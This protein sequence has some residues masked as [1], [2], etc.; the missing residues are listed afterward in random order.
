MTHNNIYEYLYLAV[1]A[2]LKA[3]SKIMEVFRSD[4]FEVEQK[5]DL[6]PVTIADKAASKI[7]EEL[8][9]SS[10]LP[11]LSEEEIFSPYDDRKNWDLFWCVDPLDGTKEFIRKGH[12]FTV[13]IALI[14]RNK[15]I[16]GVVYLPAFDSI[17]FGGKSITARKYEQVKNA[18]VSNIIKNSIQL[19][20]FQNNE[21]FVMV[22]SHSHLNAETKAYFETVFEEKGSG[23]VEILIR[24]SSLKMCLIAEGSADYYPRLSHIM[25]WDI[26][27]GH[28]ICE[29]AGCKVTDW[30]GNQ[31]IYNKPDFYMPWFKIGRIQ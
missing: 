11:Y 3:G 27:A 15:P 21:K 17:Y 30:N 9:S 31:L 5:M 18:S 6:S 23:N 2:A 16:L 25:E 12:D 4:N 8:L 10:G 24:G 26:A 14:D 1:N 13:N 22:G 20:F 28:A 29:A 7:I 19:P